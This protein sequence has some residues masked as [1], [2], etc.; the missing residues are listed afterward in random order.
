[1]SHAKKEM[2]CSAAMKAKGMKKECVPC[3]KK[4]T[5]KPAMKKG[6]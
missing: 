2:S 3:K 1:M 5:G 6:K 4:T